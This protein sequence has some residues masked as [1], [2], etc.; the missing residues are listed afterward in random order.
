MKLRHYQSALVEQIE[1]AWDRGINR[2]LGVLPT[3]G[4][5]TEVAIEAIDRRVKSGTRV[6]V[7]TERKTLCAQWCD[8]LRRHGHEYVGVIQA[9]NTIALPAPIIVATVQSIRSR[10]VPEDVSLVVID[11]S[12]LWHEAH[13]DT[14]N[15]LG[16]VKVLGLTA[17]PLRMGLGKIFE[18][19]IIGATVRSLIEHGHL[20]RPRYFAP[21]MGEIEQALAAV[22]MQAGDFAIAEL[23]KAM[24]G[25]AILGDVVGEWKKRGEDRQTLAFCV[26]KA[27]AL[28]L[29]AQFNHAGVMAAVILDDT[30]DED[31]ARLLA[32]FETGHVRILCSVGVISIGFDSPV[33]SCAILARPTRSLSLYI[34]QSGRVL[35]PFPCKSD[36]LILDH[37]GNTLTHGK[38]EDFVPPSDLNAVN[39]RTDKKPRKEKALMWVCKC[40]QAVN[41]ASANCCN[42]CGEPHVKRTAL[43]VV[44]GSL[45]ELELQDDAP[46]PGPTCDDVRRFH[47]MARWQARSKGMKLGWAFHATARRFK[48]S[49]DLAREILPHQAHATFEMPD[50]EAARWFRSDLQRLVIARLRG[51]R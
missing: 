46:P 25:K 1:K 36:A 3:G 14:L 37:A 32:A 45:K 50:D 20:V 7:V 27:H 34:Q 6:L 47:A 41:D 24:R 44:D 38:L 10:G 9:E 15:K 4:G 48:V 33:A 42:N 12:H 30:S 28:D 49:E 39:R 23:S 5:K 13:D 18:T 16:D 26:D 29:A 43:V 22:S 40:C 35:R 17:T 19:V 31:R 51:R 2:V 21:R 11:E 8:R